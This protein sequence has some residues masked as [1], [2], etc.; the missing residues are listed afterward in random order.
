MTRRVSIIVFTLSGAA[1]MVAACSDGDRPTPAGSSSGTP[2]DG[3][4]GGPDSTA[5]G[6]AAPVDPAVHA[7]LCEDAPASTTTVA[8]LALTGDPPPALGGEIE[9]GTYVLAEMN[10]YGAPQPDGGDETPGPGLSGVAGSGTLTVFAT[11]VLRI[12]SAR[13]TDV[14]NLP[15]AKTDGFLFT[16]R[17]TSLDATPVCPA[18]G[19]TRA[20][21]YSAVGTGIALFVDSTHRELYVRQ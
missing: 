17:G 18:T 13:G 19:P 21:P 4:P 3:G 2:A 7:G 5:A 6:D 16:R 14:N 11:G 8:E 9:V 20:I 12:A 10:A 1:L 15:P